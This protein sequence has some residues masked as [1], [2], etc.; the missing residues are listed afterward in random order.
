[1]LH[2]FFHR[3][4]ITP[5]GV[6]AG[7]ISEHIGQDL[8]LMGYPHIL[9]NQSRGPDAVQGIIQKVGIDTAL[10]GIQFR[11]LSAQ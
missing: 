9:V 8:D 4:H 3:D 1:M 11:F 2:F 7:G 6:A 5:H 10:Q